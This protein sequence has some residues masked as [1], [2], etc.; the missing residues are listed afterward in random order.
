MCFL[1]CCFLSCLTGSRWYQ[2]IK[3]KQRR[4]GEIITL[5]INWC[6]VVHKP[7]GILFLCNC[8]HF[9][10][11]AGG[12]RFPRGQGRDWSKG[13]QW[14]QRGSRGSRRRWAWGAKRLAGSSRRTRPCWYFWREGITQSEHVQCESMKSFPMHIYIRQHLKSLSSGQTGSSWAARI[15][16][17]TGPEGRINK[18]IRDWFCANKLQE[19]CSSSLYS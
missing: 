2:R 6:L 3:G 9:I 19:I 1:F 15:S 7:S 13:G 11:S 10:L 16:R 5:Q 17:T 8:L 4:E 18:I 12:G 14:R